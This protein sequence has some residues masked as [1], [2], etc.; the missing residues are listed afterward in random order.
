MRV[1]LFSLT[2]CDKSMWNK[3][4]HEDDDQQ[5]V[6]NYSIVLFVNKAKPKTMCWNKSCVCLLSVRH[7][8]GK[9]PLLKGPFPWIVSGGGNVAPVCLAKTHPMQ[10]TEMCEMC[11]VCCFWEKRKEKQNSLAVENQFD[12]RLCAGQGVKNWCCR[13]ARWCWWWRRWQWWCG[14]VSFAKMAVVDDACH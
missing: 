7:D 8:K 13:W 9:Q 14:I 10:L 2:D 11:E 3:L 4:V 6:I 5:S 1:C 12:R